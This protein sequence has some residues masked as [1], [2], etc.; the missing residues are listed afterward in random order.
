MKY[1]SSSQELDY[2]NVPRMIPYKVYTFII[3]INS[4]EIPETKRTRAAAQRNPNQK[5]R[6]RCLLKA[7]RAIA[8]AAGAS[9]A[10]LHPS[11]T[12]TRPLAARI[13]FIPDGAARG[14]FYRG[15]LSR[16]RPDIPDCILSLSLAVFAPH[17]QFDGA[18]IFPFFPEGARDR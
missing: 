8:S 13:P 12:R 5:P 18:A 9:T 16:S 15:D 1:S 14:R 11:Y 3:L 7:C 10:R 4:H 6:S 17:I 2:Y